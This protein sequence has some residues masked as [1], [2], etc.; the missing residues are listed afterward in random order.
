MKRAL[1]TGGA[2]FIGSHVVDVL[3]SKGHDVYVVDNFMNGRREYVSALPAGRVYEID[4]RD[5]PKLD[6]ALT[7]IAPKVVFHLAA[8]HFIPYCDL[9]PAEAVSINIHGTQ[10]LLDALLQVA[11]VERLLFASTAAVY[12]PS[13]AAHGEDEPHAPMDIYGATKSAG[14][15][16]VRA[17]GAETAVPVVI[18]RLFNAIGN[19]ETNPHLIPQI[20]AQIKAGSRELKLGNLDPK[21][22]FIDAR[23][24]AEA[25][26]ALACLPQAAAGIFNIGAGRQYSVVDVVRE[27]ERIL[28]EPITI[29][30]DQSRVRKVERPSLLANIER[31]KSATAWAPKIGLEAT[32]RELLQDTRG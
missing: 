6:A 15:A 20:I 18:G 10:V 26:A 29:V 21:R 30:Q 2:G 13:E 11:D 19:R 9:H 28:G 32:L 25:I 16:L 5:R 8:I 22:D 23:D 31:I 3:R 7:E 27:C 1:V 12:G 4:I 17:Y 14:E 24:Q